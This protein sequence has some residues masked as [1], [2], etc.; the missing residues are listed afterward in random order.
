MSTRE[1]GPGVTVTVLSLADVGRGRL[2]SVA[3]D[4]QEL[5]NLLRVPSLHRP[6]QVPGW[7]GG[8]EAAPGPTRSPLTA[9]PLRGTHVTLDLVKNADSRSMQG[10]AGAETWLVAI[11]P[12]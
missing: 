5:F 3:S 7:G 8:G 1:R 4:G 10:Q 2:C 12:S 11:S 9:Q 6:F